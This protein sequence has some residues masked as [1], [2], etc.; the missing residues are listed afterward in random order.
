M[1]PQSKVCNL[2]YHGKTERLTELPELD[3]DITTLHLQGNQLT[4]ITNLPPN[5]RVLLCHVNTLV[6]LEIPMNLVELNCENNRLMVLPKLPKTLKHLTCNGNDLTYLPELPEGLLTLLC[7]RN[8]LTHLPSL[9]DSIDTIY[10]ED[11]QLVKLPTLPMR[12]NLLHCSH[13]KLTCLPKLP[14]SLQ[15]LYCMNNKLNTLTLSPK[16]MFI[17]FSNNRLKTLPDLDSIHN[18]HLSGNP[19][20]D[21][22]NNTRKLGAQHTPVMMRDVK[23]NIKIINRFR[24]LYYSLKYKKQFRMWFWVKVM[25]PKLI[26]ANHPQ[27]LLAQLQDE[28]MDMETFQNTLDTFGQRQIQV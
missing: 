21:I 3:E 12:L 22:L 11:N 19:I 17:G 9:P 26:A 5:L 13:N 25:E 18:I 24:H 6:H 27:L 23:H 8:K 20:Y 28:N 1:T 4:T 10:C 15:T 14:D 2:A 7:S 16:L